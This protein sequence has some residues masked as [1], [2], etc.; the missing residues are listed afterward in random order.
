MNSRR[1]EPQILG[2]MAFMTD[3][4]SLL[5]EEKR[6]HDPVPKVTILTFPVLHDPVHIL[7]RKVLLDEFLVAVQTFLAFELPLLG[8]GRGRKAQERD[9][10]R[11]NPHP[12]QRRALLHIYGRHS[13]TQNR[14]NFTDDPSPV[15][16]R[17]ESSHSI[18]ES[19]D[20]DPRFIG[21]FQLLTPVIDH[22]SGLLFGDG[23]RNGPS[24]CLVRLWRR[25]ED[26]LHGNHVVKVL[27][28]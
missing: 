14:T 5:L 13:R 18:V 12:D 8:I 6:A 3:L 7:H 16:L 23:L 1:I 4:V 10:A 27:R 28:P 22:D 9:A 17:Y 2:G 21:F 24:C 11:K 20:E 25:G 15:I 26:L 19:R